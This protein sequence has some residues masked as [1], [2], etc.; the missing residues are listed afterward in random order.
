[1]E[2]ARK[3]LWCTTEF[4]P[5]CNRQ[6][7]CRRQ[8]KELAC[9]SRRSGN[10]GVRKRLVRNAELKTKRDAWKLL[11]P[12]VPWKNRYSM[13]N[14]AERKAYN[15]VEQL[16]ESGWT[17]ESFAIAKES[18]GGCCAICGV[19]PEPKPGHAEGL[20]G[21][22][23]HIKPPMPRGLLCSHCNS[24]IGFAK[25]NPLYCEAAAA[26]LRTWAV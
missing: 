12:G 16:K 1:M 25:D 7:Y 6:V 19:S 23:K 26:Y 4:S 13:M 21:D 5:R 8:C 18:Q 9:Q 14:E 11:H 10:G 24:L 17:P 3:C 20:V 22:H 15:R 2:N